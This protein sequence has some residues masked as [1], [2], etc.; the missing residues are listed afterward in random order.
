VA[1]YAHY[2]YVALIAKNDDDV[3]LAEGSILGIRARF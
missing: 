2:R 1:L 3:K